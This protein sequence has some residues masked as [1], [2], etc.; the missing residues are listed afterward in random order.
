MMAE[1]LRAGEDVIDTGLSAD[2]DAAADM[3]LID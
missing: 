2:E 1:E 3:G